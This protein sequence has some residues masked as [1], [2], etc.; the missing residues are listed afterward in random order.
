MA[1]D[2]L[3]SDMITAGAVNAAAIADGTVVA[4]EI[5]AD[6]IDGTKLADNAVNSEHMAAGSVD[7]A[8]LATGIDAAK[9]TGTLPAIDGAS[10]TG[11]S[12]GAKGADIAS[13]ATVVVGTDG[14]YFDITGTTGIS[15]QFTVAAGRTFTLQFDGAV[16]ITDNAAITLA[17]AANFTTAAG[18]ILTFT[19][20]AANTVVQTGYSLVDGGSPIAAAG[21]VAGISTSANADAIVISANEEVT[22]P[23]QPSVNVTSTTHL[24][25]ITG[26]STA[27][28]YVWNSERYDMN[29]DF[30][31]NTF[32]APVTGRYLHCIGMVFDSLNTSR[33]HLHVKLETSNEGYYMEKFNPSHFGATFSHLT[34]GS[35]IVDMDASDTAYIN[36]QVNGGSTDIDSYGDVNNQYPHWHIALLS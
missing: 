10:L 24:M 33:S 15:T 34:C 14:G 19:A 26:G 17:G 9:L 21:G 18:D 6:A 28:T 32:T 23:L 11:I 30:A 5:G 36:L 22:M 27:Y 13:A 29:S 2:K 31:S 8:H 7:N 16:V 35:F 4:A 12:T 3:T 20:V 25:D 1:L